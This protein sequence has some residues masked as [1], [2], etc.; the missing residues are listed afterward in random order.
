MSTQINQYLIHGIRLPYKW[1][2]DWELHANDGIDAWNPERRS[3][4]E[5]FAAYHRDSAYEDEWPMKDGITML[6]DGR[7]GRWI[8]IGH[9]MA[10]AK[11]GD[12]LGESE[13][14]VI[15]PEPLPSPVREF[16]QAE[17]KRV[18]G[19]EGQWNTYLVTQFR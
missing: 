19:V 14:L 8:F 11:E 12:L 16:M 2:K 7:D 9:C 6:F 13:P 4:Y 3:F 18:F 1:S 15:A 10:K 5:T 17:I